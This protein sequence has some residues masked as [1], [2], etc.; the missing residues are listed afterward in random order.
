MLQIRGGTSDRKTN[1]QTIFFKERKKRKENNRE[2]NKMF[3][4]MSYFSLQ[5]TVRAGF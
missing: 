1:K 4:A 2:R 5:L 3:L